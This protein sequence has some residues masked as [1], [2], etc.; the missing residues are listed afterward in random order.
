MGSACCVAARDTSIPNRTGRGTLHRNVRCS[1]SWSFCQDNRRRVAG[2]IDGPSYQVSNGTSINVSMEVKET[3]GSDR[4]NLS[5]QGSPLEIE[6]YET[7]I[8]QKSPVHEDMGGNMMTPPSDI[9]RASNYS[10][11]VKNLEELPN[12]IDSSTP[13]L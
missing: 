4:G 3:L 1:P 13:D 6:T 7:P 8:S 10:V 5:D 2:E 12:I 9:T 11:D